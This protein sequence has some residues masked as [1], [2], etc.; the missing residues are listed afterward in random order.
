MAFRILA[1]ACALALL[2]MSAGAATR[3]ARGG[4]GSAIGPRIGFSS[5][6][7]QL[8]LGAGML[9]GEVAPDLTFD[10]SLEVG[11]GDHRTLVGVNFD[12]HYHFR[13]SSTWSPYLGAGASVNVVNFDSDYFDHRDSETEAGGS[14]IVGAATP[15]RSGHPFFAELKLGVGDVPDIKLMAGWYFRM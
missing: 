2:P 14:V 3:A 4:G 6:P 5:G 1:L 9:V 7:D 10:P 12:L 15:T 13:T 8:V 11:V